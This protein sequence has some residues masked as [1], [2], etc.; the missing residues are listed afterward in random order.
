MRNQQIPIT[1]G[2]KWLT[3]STVDTLHGEYLFT[4]AII[5]THPLNNQTLK[6]LVGCYIIYKY[7]VLTIHMS[8]I[9]IFI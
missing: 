1:N 8:M 5:K 4:S 3:I 2:T 6:S 7:N 9:E